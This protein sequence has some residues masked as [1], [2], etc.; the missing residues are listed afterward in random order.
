[1]TL[2]QKLRQTRLK[3]GLT[4]S[5]VAGDRITRNMLSQ[6]ENDL[7]TPSVKTLEYL[8]SVL[9]VSVGWLMT[10]E[11]SDLELEI[12]GNA[13]RMLQERQFAACLALM[14]RQK[15]AKT[16]EELLILAV[17]A[18]EVAEA[19]LQ[20]EQFAAAKQRAEQAIAWNECGIYRQTSI[21]LRSKAVLVWCAQRQ[22]DAAD[23]VAAYR[24]QYLQAADAVDYHLLMARY[25]LEQEHIQ[26][27]E[28]EIWSI[29]ELP[30]HKRAEYLILRGRIACKKE[31]YENAI[32]Y[33]QQ[34][35]EC[36]ALPR[37]LKRELWRTME[38]CCKETEDYQQAYQYASKQ[39]ELQNETQPQ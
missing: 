34:A 6:L 23:A 11:T 5:Q 7:A 39:L 36:G 12:I 21:S 14:E 38:L 17:A 10:D 32:L 35:E 18:A 2:G 30:E 27:A 15:A 22:G 33:L 1:M 16:E 24:A 13:R 9:G 4:Q 28:R 25:Q 8:A 37:L 31:Q 20:E 19:L 3:A 26:A 29:A